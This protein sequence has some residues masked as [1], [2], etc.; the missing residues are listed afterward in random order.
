MP[1]APETLIGTGR[2]VAHW[3]L[4]VLKRQ[5]FRGDRLSLSLPNHVRFHVKTWGSW[6][7]TRCLKGKWRGNGGAKKGC[8][9]CAIPSLLRFNQRHTDLLWVTRG[10]ELRGWGELRCAL[11]S[12]H[13]CKYSIWCR[14]RDEIA[15]ILV[16]IYS[17]QMAAKRSAVGHTCHVL[18]TCHASSVRSRQETSKL[19]SMHGSFCGEELGAHRRPWSVGEHVQ[20]SNMARLGLKTLLR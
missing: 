10:V 15:A 2:P 1:P 4:S 16:A 3:T 6:R 13:Q 11:F 9:D 14:G 17:Q 8:A 18:L 20:E 5:G 12:V 19:P 7:G